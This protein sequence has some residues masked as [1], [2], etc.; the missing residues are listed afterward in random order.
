MVSNW[1]LLTVLGKM[2]SLGLRLQQ[3]LAFQLWLSHICLSAPG[4]AGGKG[5]VCSPLALLWYLLNPVFCEWARL[6]VGVFHRNF[7]FS[8]F[9]SLVIPQFGLLSHVS[10]LRLST[11]HSG[12][13]LTLSTDDAARTSM[14]SPRLLVADVSVW[15]DSPLAVEIRCVVYVLFLFF[16]FPHGYVAL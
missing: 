15:A 1:N 3:P 8:F 10:S 2:P 7:L 16:F 5:P 4:V 11:G 6:Q 14:P 12:P 9:F 13:I